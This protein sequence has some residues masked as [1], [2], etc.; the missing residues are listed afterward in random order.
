MRKFIQ[1]IRN[2]NLVSFQ[3]CEEGITVVE[4]GLIAPTFLMVLL[5]VFDIGFGYYTKSV[6]QGAVEEAARQASLENDQWTNIQDKVQ[7]QVLATI[8]G[9]QTNTQ[10]SFSISPEYYENYD[11]IILPEDFKDSNSNN[12]R[13]PGE[14]YI[15]RNGNKTYDLDVGLSGEGSAQDVVAITADVSYPRAFPLWAMLGISQTQKITINTYVRNQ[16][17]GARV[18]KAG[19]EICT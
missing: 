9:A 12:V 15:D 14:C 11:D 18:L 1:K 7:N 4:F 5:G 3:N 16:P 10:I 17:F 2:S 8:P 19:I 6:L 13:D